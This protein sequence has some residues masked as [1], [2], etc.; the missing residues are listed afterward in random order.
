MKKKNQK[1]LTKPRLS[2][3]AVETLKKKGGP[4]STKKRYSRRKI[5]DEIKKDI[6]F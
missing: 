6:I 2:K 3:E 4:H 5:K 1:K